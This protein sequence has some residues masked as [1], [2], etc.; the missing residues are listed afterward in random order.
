MAPVIRHCAGVEDN[1]KPTKFDVGKQKKKEMMTDLYFL[2]YN[3]CKALQNLD[4]Q[5]IP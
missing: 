4:S 3:R 1:C 2:Q 5:S